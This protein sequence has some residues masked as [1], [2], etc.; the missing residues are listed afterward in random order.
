MRLE[1]WF[2]ASLPAHRDSVA[3]IENQHTWTFGE[4]DLLSRVWA[5]EVRRRLA[6]G[7][8]AVAVL[9][10]RSAVA[11]IGALAA[12]RADAVLVP[13]NPTF[14]AAR[15]I[16]MATAAGIGAVIVDGSVG[17]DLVDEVRA[18]TAVPV[19]S[20]D[21]RK[22]LGQAPADEGMQ[23]QPGPAT[24]TVYLMFTSGSTGTPK[25]VPISH[26]NVSAFLT[27]AVRRYPMTPGDCMV[28]AYDMTF[29]LAL[30]SLFLAWV[31]GC[32]IVPASVFGL[33][34]PAKFAAKHGITVWASVPSVI[35]LAT[36][37]GKLS[38][39]CLPTLRLSMFCGEALTVDAA[40]RWAQ[41]A[42][43]STIDNAYGP[44]EL[45]SSAP[46]I[47]G[48]RSKPRA[49][50]PPSRS[51]RRSK[52]RRHWSWTRPASRPRRVNSSCAATRCSP[53][54]SIHATTNPPSPRKASPSGGGTG[55]ATW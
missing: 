36:A 52:E 8:S 18:A 16:T 35:E 39:G 44:T 47:D 38:P 3:L 34:D 11:Y 19:V 50:P 22:D 53:A 1:D 23:H 51:E 29:D 49:T 14:P 55:P 54:T 20:A 46:R 24:D 31:Q 17:A 25:G 42:P 2:S 45:T 21:A 26:A 43:A 12:L 9:A 27:A 33:A 5:A 15:T 13:L 10:G 48:S 28:Q 4:V 7:R 30:A 41:A 6:P 40:S 37:A 32:P